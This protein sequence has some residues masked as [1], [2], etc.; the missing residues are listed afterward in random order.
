MSD[1]SEQKFI[2]H[3]EFEAYKKELEKKS[4][5]DIKVSGLE[6]NNMFQAVLGLILNPFNL[7]YI[8]KL[9]EYDLIT[10]CFNRLLTSNE[11]VYATYFN[12]GK[13]NTMFDIIKNAAYTEYEY[14]NTDVS[15]YG[16]FFETVFLQSLKDLSLRAGT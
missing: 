14:K 5:Y 4:L 2:T 10:F 3:A 11:Q 13:V 12:I 7:Y 15:I 16:Q 8:D 6:E 1:S 9:N